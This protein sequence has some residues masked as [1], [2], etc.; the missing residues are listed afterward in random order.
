MSYNFLLTASGGISSGMDVAKSMAL[1]AD[2]TA[3]ARKILKQLH[4]NGETG[5]V[6]MVKEWFETV[7]KVM[8]L[9][10]SQTVEELKMDKI[11][12]KQDLI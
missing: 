4:E 2:L 3:S 9:T 7:K 5:V 6:E 10:G 8:F 12:K 1:G 11:V